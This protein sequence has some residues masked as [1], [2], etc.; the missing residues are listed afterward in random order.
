MNS[1]LTMYRS[2]QP[3]LKRRLFMRRTP[4]LPAVQSSRRQ[5]WPGILKSHVSNILAKFG[6]ASRTEVATIAVRRGLVK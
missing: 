6:V 4:Q 2:G 1:S 5:F 3:S